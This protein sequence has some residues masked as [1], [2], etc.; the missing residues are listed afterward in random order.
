MA[1]GDITLNL[2]FKRFEIEACYCDLR[3]NDRVMPETV[4]GNN[5][6]TGKSVRAGI[7]GYVYRMYFNPSHH[8]LMVMLAVYSY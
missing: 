2:K 5:Y 3:L 8:S 4:I 1:A 6:R 7:Y